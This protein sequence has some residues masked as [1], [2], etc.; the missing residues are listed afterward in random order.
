MNWCKKFGHKPD[1]HETS[2]LRCGTSLP[3]PE[4]EIRH[5]ASQAEAEMWPWMS[6]LAAVFFVALV[7]MMTVVLSP[8]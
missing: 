3:E 2:C 5:P 1:F 4:E 7:I 6:A 8:Q